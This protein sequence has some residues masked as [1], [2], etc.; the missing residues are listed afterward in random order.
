MQHDE[1]KIPKKVFRD[2]RL[3]SS[4]KLLYG[5]LMD[6]CGDLGRCLIS[7]EYLPQKYGVKDEAVKKW[8]KM[9]EDCEYIKHRKLFIGPQNKKI[10][11]REIV[12]MNKPNKYI[13]GF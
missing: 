4:A 10:S 11:S 9:L 5:E 12:M 8:L 1:I 2:K 6:L 13:E 7:N 3:S